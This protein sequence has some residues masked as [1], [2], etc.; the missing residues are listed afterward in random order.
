MGYKEII[1]SIKPFDYSKYKDITSKERLMLYAAVFL[2][3]NNVPLTFN[4]L[5]VAAF[6]SFHKHYV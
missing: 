3:R 4:Y 5:C 6:N 2:E 1:N